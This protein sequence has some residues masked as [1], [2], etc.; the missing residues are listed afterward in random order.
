MWPRCRGP[1][2]YGQATLEELKA[3]NPDLPLA[4]LAPETIVRVTYDPT[5]ECGEAVATPHGS[6]RQFGTPPAGK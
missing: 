2:A 6:P 4:H 3:L 5:G 1:F